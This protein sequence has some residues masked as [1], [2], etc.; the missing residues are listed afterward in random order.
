VSVPEA[1]AVA[2]TRAVAGVGIGLLLANQLLATE[3]RKLG[4]SLLVF[5][6]LSTIPLAMRI[7]PRL[8]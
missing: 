2:A 4:W 7:V 6:A 8:R 5:G 3:R 1:V